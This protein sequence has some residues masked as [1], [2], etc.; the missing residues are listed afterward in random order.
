MS[1]SRGPTFRPEFLE[2]VSLRS[3]F[4]PAPSICLSATVSLNIYS[5]ICKDFHF[6]SSLKLISLPPDR[7]NIFLEIVHKPSYDLEIDLLWVVEGVQR[8]SHLYPKTIIFAETIAQTVDIFEF[9]KATLGLQSYVNGQPASTNRLV[10]M[11][12][13]QVTEALQQFTLEEFRQP[14]SNLRILVSTIAFGMGVEIAN[15]RQVIHWGKVQNIATLW[16]EFGRCGRDGK[17][18]KAIWYPKS[19]CGEDKATLDELKKSTALCFRK[20][21]LQTFV[22]PGMDVSSLHAMDNRKPCVKDC[23]GEC[24]CSLCQCCSHCKVL[25]NC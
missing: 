16:Q 9:L 17:Q 25:C 11:Y 2:A 4:S 3:I 10:S 19:T 14:D 6:G 12:H 5:D 8:D 22:L 24:F 1:F 7:P 18:S 23:R 15:L 21:V 20:A 13:G